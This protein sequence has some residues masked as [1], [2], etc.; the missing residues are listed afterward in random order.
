MQN[1]NFLILTKP[2]IVF[3]IAFAL[4]YTPNGLHAQNPT[5]SLSKIKN[6]T[7]DQQRSSVIEA[8]NKGYTLLQLEGLAKAQGA[9]PADLSLLRNAWTQSE[10]D[11]NRT[12]EDNPTQSQITSFGNQTTENLVEEQEALD[13]QIENQRAIYVQK[14]TAMQTAVASFNKTGEFLD[15]LIKSW[16]SSN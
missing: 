15:N 2:V 13:Q 7:P 10:Y 4:F 6:M 3:L 5:P 8:R 16:N 9:T 12:T 14:F 11:Q 1:P